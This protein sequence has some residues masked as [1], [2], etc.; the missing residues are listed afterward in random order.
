MKQY[1]PDSAR[2]ALLLTN[3]LVPLD[4]KPLTARE[5]WNLT[6]RVDPGDLLHDDRVAITERL[7]VDEDQADR[8]RTLLDASTALGFEQERLLDGGVSLISAFDDGFPSGLRQRLG[9]TCPPFLLVGGPIDW[10]DRPGLGVVGSREASDEALDAARR[11]AAMAVGEGWP[12]VSG[13]A[14]GVDQVAMVG[15]ARRGRCCRRRSGGG[16]PQGLAQR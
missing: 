14:R 6:E 1:S 9:A 3:R 16:N 15:R 10:L 13:L 12:V 2:A 5:F 11:S 8:L 4:V 7:H